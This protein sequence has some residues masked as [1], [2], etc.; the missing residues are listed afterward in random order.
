[1]RS[2]PRPTQSAVPEPRQF[3][4]LS[5]SVKIIGYTLNAAN[6]ATNGATKT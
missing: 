2:C 6:T 1:M 3:V 4:K 5:R